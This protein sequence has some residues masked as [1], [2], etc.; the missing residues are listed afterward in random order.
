MP[1]DSTTNSTSS[2]SPNAVA[3]KLHASG[4]V[5]KT[6]DALVEGAQHITE[7]VKAVAGDTATQMKKVAETKLN[8]GREFA[9]DHLFQVAHALRKTG[10][11]LRSSDS[12]LTE[13]VGKA[14]LSVDEV[15][16]YLQTRTLSQLLG[17]AEG[18]ARREPAMFLGGSFVAGLFGG[19]FLKSATPTRPGG[20]GDGIRTNARSSMRGLPAYAS[21]RPA[22]MKATGDVATPQAGTHGALSGTSGGSDGKSAQASASTAKTKSG[23]VGGDTL[24]T[25]SQTGTR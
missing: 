2:K 15:S 9:A 17:D 3:T 1:Q 25:T 19:R 23:A 12:A 11:E 14:A 6:K 20:S 7:E 24:S 4:D 22:A 21:D 5:E 10:D 8:A 18:F 13:Y 16:H